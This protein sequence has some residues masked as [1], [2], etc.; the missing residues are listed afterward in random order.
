LRE[1]WGAHR[2]RTFVEELLKK[3]EKVEKLKNKLRRVNRSQVAICEL[4]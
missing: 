4:I 2:G 3:M 1:F